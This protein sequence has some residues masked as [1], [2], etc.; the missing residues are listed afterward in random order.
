MGHNL[1]A[2][3]IPELEKFQGLIM[4]TLTIDPELFPTGKKAYRYVMKNRCISLLKQQ[5]ER[6]GYLNSGRYFYVV[7]WQKETEFPHFHILFDSNYIPWDRLLEA[8]SK[9]RPEDAGLAVGNRPAFGTVLFSAPK[10]ASAVHAAR[11]ATKYLVKIPEQ[12]FPEWVLGMRKIRRYGT[13]RG[14]WGTK[15]E[16]RSDKPKRKRVDTKTT[17]KERIAHCGNGVDV[18]EVTESASTK[19][20]EIRQVRRW[21]GELDIDASVLDRIYDPGNPERRRRSL[22]AK[23][24]SQVVKIVS[25]AAGKPLQWKRRRGQ[26][27]TANTFPIDGPVAW[28]TAVWHDLRLHPPEQLTIEWSSEDD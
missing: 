14:F 3:L 9:H 25:C 24:L 21:V 12:G 1:R 5:L 18:F 27:Q 19:T 4:V 13:S 11:Y 26:A 10:F 8:W 23:A 15:S 6:W 2:R 17:Y 28:R 16:R 22:L 20:G 7:E